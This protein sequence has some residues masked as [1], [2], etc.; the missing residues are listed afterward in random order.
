MS[1]LE[2]ISLPFRKCEVA[3]NDFDYNDEY[4]TGNPEELSPLGKDT[5]N[6]ETGS[7]CDI[8]KRKELIAKNK[9][10]PNREYY[11]GTA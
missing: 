4:T 8:K 9:F 5:N 2:D 11:A 1:R 3:R 7:T 10:N 6:G